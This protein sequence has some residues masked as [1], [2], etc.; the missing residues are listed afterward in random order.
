MK[1]VEEAPALQEG[2]LEAVPVAAGPEAAATAARGPAE[3]EALPEA[4]TLGEEPEA[5]A[6]AAEEVAEGG[7]D[8]SK[9]QAAACE[10]EGEGVSSNS[11]AASEEAAEEAAAKLEEA[12]G[13]T[14]SAGTPPAPSDEEDELHFG[15]GGLGHPLASAEPIKA[16]EKAGGERPV[17]SVEQ[18]AGFQGEVDVKVNV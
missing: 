15:N 2:I 7:A 18:P 6:P 12:D 1:S 5:A 9:V 16:E 11:A 8:D 14:T 13:E 10:P 17:A 4:E 3:E